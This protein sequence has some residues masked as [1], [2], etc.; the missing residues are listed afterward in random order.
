MEPD[1]LTVNLDGVAVDHVRDADDIG[2]RTGAETRQASREKQRREHTCT[3]GYA[4]YM[5]RPDRTDPSSPIT[6]LAASIF[7]CCQ[8]G[9]Q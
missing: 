7:A 6:E 9:K 5:R 4:G 1:A 2:V 3:G 8:V